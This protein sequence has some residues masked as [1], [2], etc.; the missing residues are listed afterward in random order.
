MVRKSITCLKH[1]SA[2]QYN[3]GFIGWVP[4]WPRATSLIEKCKVDVKFAHWT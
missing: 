3:R 1:G 2:M 4:A